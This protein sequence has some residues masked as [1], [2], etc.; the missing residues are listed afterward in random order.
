MT[1]KEAITWLKIIKA[2][3]KLFP[4]ISASKKIKALDFAI[5]SLE[6]DEMYRLEYEKL[7]G[8]HETK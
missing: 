4:G 7:E 1:R 5:Q 8:L 6:V 3:I 2:N